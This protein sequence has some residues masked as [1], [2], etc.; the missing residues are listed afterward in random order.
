MGPSDDSRDAWLSR[1]DATP[2]HE[3]DCSG[4]GLDDLGLDTRQ[5][6]H[7]A[8]FELADYRSEGA[9]LDG[10]DRWPVCVTVNF[11]ISTMHLLDVTLQED[12][13]AALHLLLIISCAASGSPTLH[14]TQL[15][16][17]GELPST[18]FKSLV[19]VPG[20]AR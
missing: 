8:D 6:A 19:R 1:W 17:S 10:R 3:A 12:A 5:M 20:S 9:V 18:Q 15:M 2:R 16:G 4:M 11:L 13:A 14:V 7:A